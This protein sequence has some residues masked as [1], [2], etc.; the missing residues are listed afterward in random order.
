ME[1]LAGHHAMAV[2]DKEN[3]NFECCHPDGANTPG[4]FQKVDKYSNRSSGYGGAGGGGWYGKM[5]S[6]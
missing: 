6:R 4:S 2:V 5:L 1:T 3:C